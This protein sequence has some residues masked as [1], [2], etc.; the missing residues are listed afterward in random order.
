MSLARCSDPM[1]EKGQ[2][3]WYAHDSMHTALSRFK[4]RR[5]NRIHLEYIRIPPGLN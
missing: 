1:T 3:F 2:S 5:R 4:L